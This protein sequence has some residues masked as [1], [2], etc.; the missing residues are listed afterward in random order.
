MTECKHV[1]SIHLVRKVDGRQ[2]NRCIHCG[3]WIDTIDYINKKEAD[4]E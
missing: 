1:L 3:E 4:A 2:Q